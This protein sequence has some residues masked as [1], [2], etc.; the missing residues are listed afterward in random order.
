[1]IIKLAIAP[2]MEEVL[3]SA[4]S[5]FVSYRYLQHG[6]PEWYVSH[7]PGYNVYV[8]SIHAQLKDALAFTH[9]DSLMTG[10]KT[11]AD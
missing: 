2:Y 3:S 9:G 7:T 6:N 8:I 5:V 4:L 11:E 1:M 10:A